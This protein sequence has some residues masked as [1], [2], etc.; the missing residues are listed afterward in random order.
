MIY[1]S[2]GPKIGFLLIIKRGES[3]K[4]ISNETLFCVFF[5]RCQNVFGQKF[6]RTPVGYNQL[7]RPVQSSF[8]LRLFG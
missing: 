4:S 3:G 5:G 2:V 1:E 6:S 7:K 8:P